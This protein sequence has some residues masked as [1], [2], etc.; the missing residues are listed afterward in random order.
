MEEETRSIRQTVTRLNSLCASLA[1]LILLFITI[2]IFIDVILRYFFNRPS[3]WVTEI[4]TYLFLY[5]I[6][7][8]TAY[9]LQQGMHIRVTFLVDVFGRKIGRAANILTSTLATIFTL[10]LLWQASVMTWTAFK[11]HW[12]SPT[13]L[14]APFAYIYVVMV[15]GSFFLFLTFLTETINLLCGKVR[16]RPE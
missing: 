8:G 9:A 1:G 14:N 13:M 12:T 4:S 3:I 7:L 15:L 2:A 10:V 5:I 16:A 6:F 11:E